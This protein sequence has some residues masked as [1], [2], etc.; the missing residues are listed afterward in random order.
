METE[1]CYDEMI[2]PDLVDCIKYGS[3]PIEAILYTKNGLPIVVPAL[4]GSQTQTQ[5]IS[6]E[7]ARRMALLDSADE[8]I[9]VFEIKKGQMP[10][11]SPVYKTD[12][13]RN[14]K[15]LSEVDTQM[16][17]EWTDYRDNDSIYDYYSK[18]NDGRVYLGW[19]R[20]GKKLIGGLGGLLGSFTSSAGIIEGAEMNSQIKGEFNWMGNSVP[21]RVT[22]A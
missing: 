7:I 22:I 6:A 11:A 13:H 14:V 15:V 19:G 4:T 2:S 5:A 17:F 18:F 10:F 21:P 1:I 8:K 9:Y 12:P 16:K 3:N 20:T